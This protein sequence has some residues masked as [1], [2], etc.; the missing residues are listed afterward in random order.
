[1]FVGIVE[2][3]FAKYLVSYVHREKS[4][5]PVEDIAEIEINLHEYFHLMQSAF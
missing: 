5:N 1:L 2:S 3:I 4:K